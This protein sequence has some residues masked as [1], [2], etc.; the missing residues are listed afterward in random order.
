[1]R[2]DAD[3]RV[4]AYTRTL[5]NVRAWIVLN[6]STEVVCVDAGDRGLGLGSGTGAGTG[7]A[8]S[9]EGMASDGHGCHLVLGNYPLTVDHR[10]DETDQDRDVSR[11][12]MEGEKIITLRGYEARVYIKY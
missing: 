3:D 10:Q 8:E 7:A 2:L 12:G 5:G 9:P 1:M 11:P 4:L 6:F